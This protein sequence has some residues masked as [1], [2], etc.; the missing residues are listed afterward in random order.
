MRKLF[1]T[2]TMILLLFT[3]IVTSAGCAREYTDSEHV[4]RAREFHAQGDYQASILELKNAL[5]RNKDSA[6][7]RWLLG[8]TYLDLGDVRSAGKEL[9]HARRLGWPV[10][11]VIPA[12][13]KALLAQG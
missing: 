8:K 5:T 4:Q 11:D 1:K 10:D 7:A 3:M 12:L 6:E 9:Q 2:A 13:A